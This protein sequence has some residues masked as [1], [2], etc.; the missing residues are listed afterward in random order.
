MRRFLNH[1]DDVTGDHPWL[2]IGCLRES[3]RLSILHALV[4]VDFQ[5]LALIRNL[6][7]Q[8][9]LASVF[10][11]DNFALPIALIAKSLG[12]LKH[13]PKPSLHDLDTPPIASPARLNGFLFP[14][15]PVALGANGSFVET[16]LSG[17]TLIQVLEGYSDTVHQVFAFPWPL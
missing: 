10:R 2:L 7:P 17:F 8:T 6:L 15:L 9:M 3:D 5:E 4:N 11:V 1:D 13:W 12:L 16:K 14:A